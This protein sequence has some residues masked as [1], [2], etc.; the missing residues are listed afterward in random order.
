MKAQHVITP[1][2]TEEMSSHPEDNGGWRTKSHQNTSRAAENA[3]MDNVKRLAN[4]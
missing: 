1:E 4:T 2:T 3:A